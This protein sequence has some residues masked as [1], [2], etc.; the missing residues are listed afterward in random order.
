MSKHHSMPTFRP[1]ISFFHRLDGR[2]KLAVLVLAIVVALLARGPL[3]YAVAVASTAALLVLGR[4]RAAE[5]FSPLLWLTPFF[6][7][8]FLMNFLFFDSRD[9]WAR[10]WIF[11]PSLGGLVQGVQVVAHV[12]LVMLASAVILV[13]TAPVEMTYALESLISPFRRLGL[14]VARI[15]LILSVAIQFIPTLSEETAAIREAQT[16]RGARFES[17]NLWERAKAYLPL[18]LPIFLNAFRRADEL[19]TAMEARGYRA[20]RTRLIRKSAKPS[21]RDWIMLAAAAAVCALQ[22]AVRCWR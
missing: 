16:A 1:G 2:V 9:P 3:T 10:W 7:V 4:L 5:S 22:I 18:M 12:V 11:S 19:S 17:S 15:A 6:V 14:P 13:T 21:A 8:V 20:D